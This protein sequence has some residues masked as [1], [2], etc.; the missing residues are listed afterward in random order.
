MTDQKNLNAARPKVERQSLLLP[1]GLD[2]L[3]A[4]V[5]AAQTEGY[6]VIDGI[7]RLVIESEATDE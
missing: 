3:Q 2:W 5:P 4:H 6:V 7:P 1:G